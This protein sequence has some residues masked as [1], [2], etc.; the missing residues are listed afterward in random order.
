MFKICFQ[1]LVLISAFSFLFYS[2]RS[3]LSK[4]MILEY[5]R[6]G[7][8]K[9]RVLISILQL[10]AVFGL[11]LGLYNSTLLSITSFLLTVMMLVA[12][13]V[14]FKIRDSFINFLPAIFYVI[15][16][17]IIFYISFYRFDELL[18]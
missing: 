6:W 4:N 17:L 10:F 11:L 14:R 1:S 16:N 12:I 13:F 18:F 15:L 3:L 9:I 5:S 2:I 8:N 7:L